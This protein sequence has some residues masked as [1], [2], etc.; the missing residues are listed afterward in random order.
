[1]YF[2]CRRGGKSISIRV[3]DFLMK[4]KRG[5][6]LLTSMVSC[7]FAQNIFTNEVVSSCMQTLVYS[8]LAEQLKAVASLVQQ[9]RWNLRFALGFNPDEVIIPKRPAEV[10]TVKGP[11]DL[12]YSNSL[13]RNTERGYEPWRTRVCSKTSFIY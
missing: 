12:S 10:N 8:K 2:K 9:L 1:M 7:L 4:D 11:I 13:R 5:G 6:V 3:I